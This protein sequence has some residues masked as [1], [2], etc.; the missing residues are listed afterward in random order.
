MNM[1]QQIWFTARRY[2]QGK[3]KIKVKLSLCLIKHHTMKI[4]LLLD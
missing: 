4:Y 3:D 1:P 2:L